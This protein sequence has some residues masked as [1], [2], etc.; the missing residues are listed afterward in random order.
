MSYELGLQDTDLSQ[1]KQDETQ[2][3]HAIYDGER[4]DEIN[5][6]NDSKNNSPMKGIHL[7]SSDSPSSEHC[8]GISSPKS[9]VYW[10]LYE[11]HDSEDFKEKDESLEKDNDLLIKK[12]PTNERKIKKRNK[13]NKEM[14]DEIDGWLRANYLNP[15]PSEEVKDL[16]MRKFNITRRQLKVFLTNHRKRTLYMYR[17]NSF[18][19]QQVLYN[20]EMTKLLKNMIQMRNIN[21]S[22][23]HKENEEGN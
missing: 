3:M 10:Y 20:K 22:I 4:N 7:F 21:S 15:Y 13:Y 11:Q 19:L 14:R 18:S 17:K 23:T 9:H 8:S 12:T 5:M 2:S 1:C 6:L 16:W